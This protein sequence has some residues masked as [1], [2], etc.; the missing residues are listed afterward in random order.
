MTQRM[1]DATAAEELR[2]RSGIA[3]AQAPPN[4]ANS[5]GWGDGLA[6]GNIGRNGL[7]SQ[8]DFRDF[9][10][11]TLATRAAE[12]YPMSGG[13]WNAGPQTHYRYGRPWR[14]RQSA[15]DGW[16]ERGLRRLGPMAGMR[17]PSG[18]T[19]LPHGAQHGAAVRGSRYGSLVRVGE[20]FTDENITPVGRNGGGSGRN[21]GGRREYPIYIGDEKLTTL[22][23]NAQ[24]EL[25]DTGRA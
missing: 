22:V 11:Q 2:T 6:H 12:D 5:G 18:R 25:E 23:L 9:G 13:A 14:L 19:M 3:P 20:N 1:P 21:Q 17:L 10:Q 16:S 4:G 24:N 7:Q 15:G 8:R